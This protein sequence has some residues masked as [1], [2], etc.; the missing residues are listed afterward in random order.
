MKRSNRIAIFG[1]IAVLVVI[2]LS[3][4]LAPFNK[5]SSG[6]TYGRSPDGY[7]AWYAFMQE[8]KTP[9]KRWRKPFFVLQSE[10]SPAIL[11]RVQGFDE[12]SLL[13]PEES[14]VKAGNTIV[15]LG[16]RGKA[17]GAEFATMQKSPQ[18]DV[19]IETTRRQDVKSGETVALGDD[20][21]AV[22]WREKIGQGEVIFSTTPYL[23]ANAYQD[24]PNNFKY[25]AELVSKKNHQI[26]V[27]EYIHGYVD[28]EN[29]DGAGL[30]SEGE[31][32]N[33]FA[34]LMQ[35]PLLP[36]LI[37][38]GV[39]LLVLVWAKN[40]RF[41]KAL[42]LETK[43]TDNS[44][45]YIQALASVLQKADATDFVV[46]MIAKDSQLQLQKSL[47]LGQILL[48]K[49]ELASAWVEITEKNQN[50]LDEVL[51]Q[52]SSKNS[53][54]EKEL[55]DWLAKWNKLQEVKRQ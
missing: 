15:F 52:K 42:V 46:E 8:R 5:I 1:S 31:E 40:R 21:G 10:K 14:W 20:F 17:T 33:P 24:Y 41:G 27:D 7:G 32:G 36:A 44:E 23:A 18:G 11:L 16:S 13:P 3:L 2:I 39:L 29:H 38:S 37:Q 4:F 48:D 45:A 34:Y 43:T 28:R 55:M 9:V 22:V 53:I 6:S 26:Y 25:L 30:P 54:S 19:Q 49:D 12:P 50:Q 47:G 35:T 51:K